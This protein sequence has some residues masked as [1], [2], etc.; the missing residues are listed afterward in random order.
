MTASSGSASIPS[1]ST[2]SRT[3][4]A[5]RRNGIER[6]WPSSRS[7]TG[8]L[9]KNA[10]S[11]G[12]S[13][14]PSSAH[15]G[16]G[17]DT[18]D[19][20]DTKMSHAPKLI[21][22][23]VRNQIVGAEGVVHAVAFHDAP[24]LEDRTENAHNPSWVFVLLVLVDEV[25]DI[26]APENKHLERFDEIEVDDIAQWPARDCSRIPDEARLAVL[27]ARARE[28]HVGSPAADRPL[29][30]DDPRTPRQR[31]LDEREP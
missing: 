24:D 10:E 20:R 28:A 6:C 4:G 27:A 15:P 14:G 11:V 5:S 21:G 7:S 1:S 2:T 31:I 30:D 25:D 12:V 13:E 18:N 9:E 23:R 3:F 22:L 29:E 19:R 17:I 8:S 26:E 16:V